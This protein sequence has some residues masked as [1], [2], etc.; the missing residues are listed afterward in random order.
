MCHTPYK[1]VYE[2]SRHRQPA[3]D[4]HWRLSAHDGN[5]TVFCLAAEFIPSKPDGRTYSQHSF[6]LSRLGLAMAA[7]LDLAFTRGRL[8]DPALGHIPTST[9]EGL[10]Q[11]SDLAGIGPPSGIGD[12]AGSIRFDKLDRLF[13]ETTTEE[14]RTICHHLHTIVEAQFKTPFMLHS[15]QHV[16][17]GNLW[18]AAQR[19]TDQHYDSPERCKYCRPLDSS[20]S[21]FADE[22]FRQCPPLA[23]RQDTFT[24]QYG[25]QIQHTVEGG[26]PVTQ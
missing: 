10:L 17:D 16:W 18:V 22:R 9:M 8:Y 2:L 24:D 11:L 15:V 13:F 14:L 20:W 6:P 25:C 1:E 23:V 19:L 12:A 21:I 26:I 5:C 4:L 3:G 7:S